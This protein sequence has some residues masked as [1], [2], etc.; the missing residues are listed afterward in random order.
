MIIR[1]VE[2]FHQA[3]NDRV[4]SGMVLAIVIA[5]I[6]SSVIT[7]LL[8][9]SKRISEK[10]YDELVKRIRSWAVIIFCIVVPIFFGREATMLGVFLLSAYCFREFSRA[11]GLFRERLVCS[12]VV[13]GMALVTFASL[14]HWYG[15][16]VALAPLTVIS[17]AA[18]P[19]FQDRPQGYLQRV[20][21]G[22][23]GF[24]LFGYSFAHLA[25]IANDS[26][27]RAII[28][29]IIVLVEINDV[30]AYL[31]GSLFGKRKLV[32]NTSPGKTIAGAAGALVCTSLL[33]VFLGG[34]VF[35]GTVMA[36]TPL[37]LLLG[38]VISAVGQLGDLVL[39]SIKRDIGVKDLG[40][41][42][43]GHG[44]LLDRFDSLTLVAPAA[45]HFIGYFIGFGLDQPIRIFTS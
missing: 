3:L 18:I 43:P 19:I 16:F 32:P 31:C 5:L 44:G 17:V 22:I 42:I 26:N 23:L 39:S 1:A 30:F 14:D 40:T 37:L 24:M 25:F 20:G 8:G 27:F 4:A 33:T 9:K 12:V 38:I 7:H 45:F 28:L 36:A 2:N 35:A 10:R 6:A 41:S 13:L 29:M 21:L 11:T 15:F 34:L